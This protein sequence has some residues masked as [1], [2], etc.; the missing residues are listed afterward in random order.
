MPFRTRVQDVAHEMH[1]AA[2]P[3]NTLK[4][5]LDGV[6]Q[7]AVMI[8]DDEIHTVQPAIDQPA[9]ELRPCGFRLAVADHQPQHFAIPFLVHAH[10]DQG[11]LWDHTVLFAYL[12]LHRVN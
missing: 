12:E 10:S 6:D 2:L 9:E 3:D 5:A 7:S 11:A 1:L 4:L 8:G